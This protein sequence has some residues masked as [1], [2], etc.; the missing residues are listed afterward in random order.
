MLEASDRII[1]GWLD[2]STVNE[3]S[4]S[5]VGGDNAL[6]QVDAQGVNI[7]LDVAACEGCAGAE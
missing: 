5:Q 6:M 3:L 2:V 1:K 7:S 4:V